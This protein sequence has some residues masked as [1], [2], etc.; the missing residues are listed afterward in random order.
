LGST[1]A[2]GAAAATPTVGAATTAPMGALV[3]SDKGV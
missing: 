2:V 3:I 1:P